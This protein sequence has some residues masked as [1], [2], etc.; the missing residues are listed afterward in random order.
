MQIRDHSGNNNNE[1]VLKR[2]I[3]LNSITKR[4]SK[5]SCLEPLPPHEARKTSTAVQGTTSGVASQ[6]GG[7]A[8]DR[9]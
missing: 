1:L 5:N 6:S 4:N 3:K 2:K 9:I 7:L 8:F